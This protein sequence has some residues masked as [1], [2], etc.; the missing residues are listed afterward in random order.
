MVENQQEETTQQV[1]TQD[2][3]SKKLYDGLVKDKLYTKSFEDF[4]KKYSTPEAI[5][6]LHT[7]LTKDKMY[8]KSINDF[9][10]QYFPEV[11][12]KGST[13]PITTTSKDSQAGVSDGTTSTTTPSQVKPTPKVQQVKAVEIKPVAE[14]P[15]VINFNAVKEYE[16]SQNWYKT[17]NDSYNLTKQK[18]TDYSKLDDFGTE[19]LEIF[20]PQ[21]RSERKA[22]I[23]RAKQD[24]D[25]AS[26]RAKIAQEKLTSGINT[27]TDKAVN[28]FQKY[29]MKSDVGATTVD[30]M[31]VSAYAS[32]IAKSIGVPESGYYQKLIYNQLNASIANKILEPDVL[33]ETEKIYKQQTGRNLSDDLKNNTVVIE[34]EKIKFNKAQNDLIAEIKQDSSNKVNELKNIYTQEANTINSRIKPFEDIINSYSAYLKDGKFT[35]TQEQY[36]QYQLAYTQY[37]QAVEQKKPILNQLGQQF[38]DDQNL[39]NTKANAKFRRQVEELGRVAESKI[40]EKYTAQP[41]LQKKMTKI[42]S[43]AYKNVIN[44]NDA[45]KKLVNDAS[46]NTILSET[47]SFLSALGGSLAGL[48]SQ[49]NFKAG[50]V[51]GD[52]IE[53]KFDIG[54]DEVNSF[55]DLLNPQ[56]LAKSLGQLGGG[57]IIPMIGTAGAVALTKGAGAG[58]FVQAATSAALSWMGETADIA[59]RMKK[60]TFARTG[61][62]VEA[63]NAAAESIKGQRTSMPFYALEGLPFMGKAVKL[64]KTALTR[65]IAGGIAEYIPELITEYKQNLEEEAIKGTGDYRNALDYHTWDKFKNTALQ[66]APVFGLGAV[67]QMTEVD[68]ATHEKE[69]INKAAKAFALK[70]NFSELAPTQRDQFLFDVAQRQGVPFASA[71]LLASYTSGNIDKATFEG[72]SKNLVNSANLMAKSKELGLTPADQKIFT[73]FT[74]QRD[75]IQKAVEAEQ[76]PTIKKALEA[77]LAD[78]ESQINS[79]TTNKKADYV[80]LTYPNNEQYV[81]TYAEVDNAMNDANF[82]DAL[83][84]GDIKLDV[85]GENKVLSGKIAQL[86]EQKVAAEAAAKKEIEVKRA[87]IEGKYNV[88]IEDNV[89]DVGVDVNAGED[90]T[91]ENLEAAK[92]E[93]RD[94]GIQIRGEEKVSVE[95]VPEIKEGVSEE[96]KNKENTL[97][98]LGALSTEEKTNK[99]V[100]V[101]GTEIP[102]MGN[103]ELIADAYHKGD[104][105][106]L[107][108]QVNEAL[109]ISELPT[110][111]KPLTAKEKAQKLKQKRAAVATKGISITSKSEITGIEERAKGDENK[112]KVLAAAKKAIETLK[113]FF[114]GMDINI[115]E[116]ADSYNPLMR[117]V[118]GVEDS[119]GNFQYGENEDGTY[120]GSIDIN[121]SNATET[122]VAHEVTH[123]VLLKAFGENPALFKQFRERMSGVLS[124]ELDKELTEFENRYKGLEV[125]P[126][127]YLTQL[128]AILA[129][130]AESVKYDPS[131]LRKVAAII[132]EFVSKITNGKVTPFQSEADFKNF[133]DFLNTISKAIGEGA[134]I[135]LETKESGDAVI[136]G[137]VPLAKIKNKSD[138]GFKKF[139]VEWKVDAKSGITLKVPTERKELYNVVEKSGGAVVIIN[140]DATGIGITKD[141]DLLQGGIGYTFIG[142]NVDENVGFA[143]SNDGKIASFYKAVV[144]AA[145]K[146]DAEFPEMKGKPVSVFVMVQTPAAMFGNAYSAD[147]FGRVLRKITNSKLFDTAETKKEL[148]EFIEDYKANNKTGKKYENSL[149]KLSDLIKTTDFSK[150]ESL[151]KLVDLLIT[152]RVSKEDKSP[153]FGF[154]IRRSF[155]EKFFV[156]VGTVKQGAAARNLRL[157]LKEKGYNHEGFFKEF[158][159]KNVMSLLEGDTPGRKQ[160]DGNFTLT[161]FFVDPYQSKESYIENS[162]KGT[163]QHK[164]FNSK[165]Y[166][167]DPFVLDGKYYVDKMF[168]EARFLTEAGEEVPVQVAAAGSLYPRTQ[169]GAK[170]IIERAKKISEG[171]KSK[172]QLPTES[173]NKALEDVTIEPIDFENESENIDVYEASE[174]AEKIAKDNGVNILRGKDLRG[175]ALNKNGDVIGGLWTEISGNEF[176]FDIAIDKTAQGKGVGEKLVNEAISEFNAQNYEDELKYKID[177]TN[178]IMEKLLSKYGFE[179]VEKIPGH[180]IM[181]HPTNNPKLKA[182]LLQFSKEEEFNNKNISSQDETVQPETKRTVGETKINSEKIQYNGTDA[183]G[184]RERT[185]SDKIA[186]RN[187][188]KEKIK[189]PETNASLKAANSYNES[190]GLPEVTSHK[191]KPSDPA[192]QTKIAKTYPNLQDVNSPTYKETNVERRIYSEYKNKYPEIFKEYD[193]KD[194]KDLVHKS[195]EQLIKETQLQYDALPIKVTFHEN[196]E[197]NYENNFEMLDD[198]HNFNHL[199]VYKGGADHTELG[200]KTIDSKGLTAND[201]FRAVH[202]YY[203]HSVEGYQ[204][205][206]DGEE[207]AWIEHS[208]M[209][210]P[211]AQWA[212]SS[213]TRGQNSWVNYSG[214]ND[215]VLESI[216][217]GSALKKEGKK[218]GNQ[219]MIDEGEKLLS[220]LYDDFQFA[221][222]KA[223]VLP[224]DFSDVSK[225]HTTTISEVPSKLK[226]K[227]QLPKQ[228]EKLRA[229]EQAELDSKIPNAEKYRV[230]GKVDRAKLTNPEDI[231]AFD[232][233]YKKYD[234]L[235]T[236]LLKDKEV[237]SGVGDVYESNSELSKI[238]TKQEYADYLKTIFPGSQLKDV[239]YHRSNEKFDQF[240]NSKLNKETGGFFDFAKESGIER[241]GKNLYPA[242]LNISKLGEG[243]ELKDGQDGVKSTEMLAD[244]KDVYSVPNASQIHILGNKADIEGFKNWKQELPAT[245]KS[246]SE[247]AQDFEESEEY[248]DLKDLVYDYI[249]ERISLEDTLAGITED[250]EDNSKK[251]RDLIIQAYNELS[252]KSPEVSEIK[253]LPEVPEVKKVEFG[254]GEQGRQN[255]KD[256]DKLT[257]TIPNSGALT[258]YLSGETIERVEGETPRNEQEVI[259]MQLNPALERGVGIINKAKELFGDDYVSKL[260]DYV[261]TE[262]L[263]PANKALIYVSLENDLARQK[264][265][266]PNDAARI[267]KMQDLVRA[268]SQAYL[269]SNALAINMGR[270]RELNMMGID[271]NEIT[272]RV[273]SSKQKN[274]KKKVETAVQATADDINAEA[275]RIV[276]DDESIRVRIDEGVKEEIEK[277]YKNLSTEKKKVVDKRLSVLDKLKQKVLNKYSTRTKSQV[278][279]KSIKSKSDVNNI[280]ED[281][282]N[283]IT[284]AI[285]AGVEINAAIKIGVDKIKAEIEKTT[286]Q[287]WKDEADF[288]KDL[289]EAFT[290]EGLTGK[291]PAEKTQE[292][293]LKQE[294]KK[295]DAEIERQ[296]AV[297]KKLKE[298]LANYESGEVTE[299]EVRKQLQDIPEIEELKQK[300]KEAKSAYYKRLSEQKR[301][302]DNIKKLEEELDRVKNRREKTPKEKT[303]EVQQLTAEEKALADKIKK[304]KEAWKAEK[305]AATKLEKE[306]EKQQAEQER[307]Q[308]RIAVL[309]EKL[310]ALKRGEKPKKTSR[311][312]KLDTPEIE[313]LKAEIK[314][315]Q[316]K[317]AEANAKREKTVLERL[318]DAKERIKKQIESLREQ[319]ANKQ[320]AKKK[321]KLKPDAELENLNKQRDALISLLDKYVPKPE[322]FLEERNVKTAKA[323]LENEILELNRQIQ[324]GQ[325]DK[326]N[327]KESKENSELDNLRAEKEARQA[328]LEALDPTPKMFVE[329][330]LIEQGYGRQINVKTKL[331]VEKRWVLDWKKLAGEEGSVDRIRE[332]VERALRDKG[333]TEAD[334]LR[335]QDSFIEEYNNLRASIVEKSMN[336]IARINKTVVSPEQKS[337]GK[338]LAEMYNYG[339]FDKDP[340]EFE[341]A[342]GKAIGVNALSLENIDR[343]REL[344]E[345][346]SIM[347]NE[348]YQGKKLTQRQGASVERSIE[349]QMR[350]ILHSEQFQRGNWYLKA[351]DA[352]RTW[353]DASQRM[354]LNTLKQRVENPLSGRLENF[355]TKIGYQKGVSKALTSQQRELARSIYKEI[356][357]QKGTMY[358][359]VS[360][361]YIAK[362]KLDIYVNRLSDNEIVQAITSTVMGRTFLDA[363]DSFYKAK[364]TELKFVSSLIKIL[365]EDRLIDGKIEQGMSKKEAI[366][367][368][369]E[370]LSGQSFEDAKETARNI[371]KK[372]NEKAG[373]KMVNDSEFFV[374]R[375]ANDIVKTSLVNG[376]KITEEMLDAAF[377]SSYRAAGRGIGHVPNNWVSKSLNSLSGSLESEINEAIKNE[378]YTTAGTFTLISIILRNIVNPFVGGG[379]NWVALKME[380]S[381]LGLFS[382]LVS[383]IKRKAEFDLTTE[384]GMKNLEQAMYEEMKIKD[385][386]IRGSIGG[387]TTV[388]AAVLMQGIADTDEYQ[389][390]L[391][392]NRWAAKYL[393]LITP[394][395]VLAVLA[396]K[397]GQMKRY[398]ENTFNKNEDFDKSRMVIDAMSS[399]SDGEVLKNGRKTK[400][401]TSGL[402]GQIVGGSINTPIPWRTARDVQ[403]VYQGV[404]GEVPYS[405]AY[406]PTQSF[407]EGYFRGGILDYLG[408]A[409]E[410]PAMPKSKKSKKSKKRKE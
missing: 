201:K 51:F 245:T 20:N 328:I 55:I 82:S 136:S 151:K 246:K 380:K 91:P 391:K 148:I 127:E 343:A 124:A 6:A 398:I 387:L 232:E 382:A 317:I 27:I 36:N 98:A 219:E 408:Y 395:I 64:G 135:D 193:I 159:D 264:I 295:L 273:L 90:V 154:D 255:K 118:K 278:S 384:E 114:P 249:T 409:P 77:R 160:A 341:N 303:A 248:N 280:I 221:E 346:L 196:G 81:L 366:E 110:T 42:Y 330:A 256:F 356:V 167:V 145:N 350:E 369:A 323:K 353:M 12:K 236:P 56:K 1:P 365:Q 306:Y 120:F 228:I 333:Y 360:S 401:T 69:L 163:Y 230:D 32:K 31:K 378:K 67:G 180:T 97:A 207:N 168:P 244:G 326:F 299:P 223:I 241:Y 238:G 200:S 235:I 93:L 271:V 60:D 345:A 3:P 344:A 39:I 2:P 351:A 397:G 324:K 204:F 214:V 361:Q 254:Q 75:N 47:R 52:F 283:K 146:R 335:M 59:G 292:E 19:V 399:L 191:Y 138:L 102:I 128:S 263:P 276:I 26:E 194:Y 379:T 237:G 327:K 44:K 121:L 21:I 340:N 336:E 176:S 410:V 242:L 181:E 174:T 342:L 46:G 18:N 320:R 386:F 321:G 389:K 217:T 375:L 192:L 185:E 152:N 370:K 116:S 198:V 95:E 89:G 392:K 30:P 250:L 262:N 272:D 229:E 149:D 182:E 261:E 233:I 260:L 304:E 79:F 189:N 199:W 106:E 171:V 100:T 54:R 92:Q 284:N 322:S 123:A 183:I 14:K 5:T 4:N 291:K 302:E 277:I 78:Y 165:F 363:T 325:K 96:I 403:Q 28:E 10:S 231:K 234:K 25:K 215:A 142:A 131:F 184:S 279:D 203:G 205:G 158:G 137:V 48:S 307:Q 65:A 7:G 85:F 130:G 197:G 63:E 70:T 313:A 87:E 119:R 195:Y 213:E 208:K 293:L 178:P 332:N 368:V 29:T 111:K 147:Y 301:M 101:D 164:Q 143:A 103:E 161:G 331:G 348:E 172:S 139:N 22:N 243:F 318:D 224:P 86:Q 371:I 74:L 190:V 109:G 23:E 99:T 372:I 113:S 107:I 404:T 251:T 338:R 315:E 53:G 287:K 362:G 66:I 153:K 33:K 388:L 266:N 13:T 115:H 94:A 258:K 202:D 58:A 300:V 117:S 310:A 134:K 210:S 206:K 38:I 34:D 247:K 275:A 155:F 170:Q 364:I 393:S 173:T 41:E 269:R 129:A 105:P 270:L 285:K 396:H 240:D 49:N 367:Y 72:M 220:T 394:E 144:D 179:V 390:W 312:V 381:G 216:K 334:I 282:Y 112:L 407:F 211:L 359:D 286:G 133:V 187:A 314:Q 84:N 108:N 402:T 357:L 268:K 373:K 15:V 122:T 252:G 253:E 383:M 186:S 61:N 377:N 209:F 156:G 405:V 9:Q 290:Q 311:E 349:E 298:R 35:G 288:K 316:K 400:T 175:V 45:Y 141:K 150:K 16:E 374:N 308:E 265:D 226:S 43:E 50:E 11:K 125:A 267:E 257:S 294:Q 73:A 319:I 177:V 329:N 68:E 76:D 162:K 24:L 37:Q 17:V 281:G 71:Y 157:K 80:V 104:S 385:K 140:S 352:A 212:L 188:A 126:E 339:L 337:A 376:E 274:N 40:K 305:E 347:Y 88:A 297:I 225:F 218:L 358:G 169:K 355:Y 227:S 222:Q 83:K 354:L 259:A 239:F 62:I 166:G 132:N 296:A 57:M 289:V 406:T 8:T 309:K